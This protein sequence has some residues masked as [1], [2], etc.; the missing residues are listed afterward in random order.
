MTSKG[1]FQPKAFYDSK[2]EI[3]TENNYQFILLNYFVSLRAKIDVLT[4]K[5]FL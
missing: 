4:E 1:P 5:V 3:R 2:T